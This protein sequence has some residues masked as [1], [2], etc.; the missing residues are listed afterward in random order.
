MKKIIISIVSLFMLV[1]CTSF[2]SQKNDVFLSGV[3]AILNE[4]ITLQRSQSNSPGLIG[5]AVLNHAS[6][7]VTFSDQGFGLKI[8]YYDEDTSYWDEKELYPFPA[9]RPK[10]LP[11]KTSNISHINTWSIL[12]DDIVNALPGEYRLYIEGIGDV[13]GKKYGAFFE[14]TIQK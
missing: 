2:D 4:E 14:F 6:E 12:E 9:P 11:A 5:F 13:T 7:T 1:A 10:T 8:Y 3:D